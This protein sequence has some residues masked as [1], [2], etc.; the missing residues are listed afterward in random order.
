MGGSVSEEVKLDWSSAEVHD[1]KLVIGL[2]GKPQKA[3]KAAFERTTRLLGRGKWEE[4]SLKKGKVLLRPI[5]PGEEDRVRHFLESVVLEANST[6]ETTGEDI[7]ERSEDADGAKKKEA[8]EAPEDQEMTER[9]R[10]F[11]ETDSVS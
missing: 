7:A 1:G 8:G 9:L 6:I 3:W 4:V 10:S 5:T 11:A 2:E